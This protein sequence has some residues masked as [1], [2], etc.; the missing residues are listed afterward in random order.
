[1]SVDIN[2]MSAEEAGDKFVQCCGSPAF[3]ARMAAARPFN[4]YGEMVAA[5]RR[6]WWNECDMQ[7]WKK[8]FEAHPRIGDV[9]QL[10]EKFASTA[11]WCEG[12]QSAALESSNEQVLQ[13]LADWN[14]K[15]EEKFGH[16]FIVCASGKPAAEILAAL[17]E[18][19]PNSPY[20]ELGITAGEQQKITEIRL[21]KLGAVFPGNPLASASAPAR[22]VGAL[23]LQL[24]GTSPAEADAFFL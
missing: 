6:V 10:R 13:E 1:M 15:Y 18:R 24:T 17:K 21:E 12:E 11:Q 2:A 16:I 4:S 23:G 19:Y 20:A 5:S 3:G 14:K 9:S 22:R 8:A 7:E